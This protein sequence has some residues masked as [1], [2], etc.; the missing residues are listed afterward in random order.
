MNLVDPRLTDLIDVERTHALLESF[1]NAVGIPSAI[2]DLQGNVLAAS[3][4]QRI[5]TDYH[6]K[7]E[8]TCTRCRESDTLLANE[9]LEGKNFSL[10]RCLNGLTDAASPIVIEGRHL[11]NAFIGQFLMEEPDLEFFRAQAGRFGFDESGYLAALTEVPIVATESLPSVLDFLCSFAEMTAGHGLRRLQHLETE[12]QLR[13]AQLQ[14]ERKNERLQANQLDLNRAQAVSKTGCWRLDV[15]ENVLNWSDETCRIFGVPRGVPLSYEMFLAKVHPDDR[16]KLDAAWQR[17]LAGECYDIEH[18]IVVDGAVKWVR[19]RAELEF[20]CHG[21]L[22]GGFGTVHDITERKHAEAELK[23]S[24]EWFRVTLS[25]IG[26]AVIATDAAGQVTFINPVGTE[27]TGWTFKAA[28][29][30][31]VEKVFRIIN[32][33][34]RQPAENIVARVLREGA[35]FPPA[36]FPNYPPPKEEETL[37]AQ[38][39]VSSA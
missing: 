5:C 23:S 37:V 4:G 38:R 31:P 7:N 1:S 17:A 20:D 14:L 24:R 25:S 28:I 33:M 30:Q 13:Q 26:D 35:K 19:E 27:L 3:S 29:G 6:R 39:L 8:V 11:A 15:R 36:G 2:I 16:G 21:A 9:L 18:R 12:R 32:E 34:T 10:Y 22:Q